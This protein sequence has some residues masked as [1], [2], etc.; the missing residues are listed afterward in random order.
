M[1]IGDVP[2]Q[3]KVVFSVRLVGDQPEKVEPREKSCGKLNVVLDASLGVVTPIGRVGSGKD[4]H[5]CVQTRHDSRL[6]EIVIEW[7]ECIAGD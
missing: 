2:C 3:A 4:G 1:D 5:S 6:V 7:N